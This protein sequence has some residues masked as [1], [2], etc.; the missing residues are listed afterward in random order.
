MGLSKNITLTIKDYE[1]NLDK[2]IKFYER[3][4]INLCFSILEYGIVVKD[5][6]PINK[7]MPIQ[8]LRAFMLIE[9]PEGADFAEATNIE[10]NKVVFNLG[11]RYSQFIGIGRMQIVIKDYDGCRVTLPEFFFEIKESINSNWDEGTTE[12]P[13]TEDERIITDELGRPIETVKLSE[14]EE[15]SDITFDTYTMVIDKDGNKKMKVQAVADTVTETIIEPVVESVTESVKEPIRLAV[16]DDIVVEYTD[17]E[18]EVQFPNVHNIV[19]ETRSLVDDHITNHPKGVEVVNDLISGGIDKALS[20]EQGKNLNVLVDDHITNHP[21]GVEVVDDLVSGGKDKALSAEQGKNLNSLV[22]DHITNHP[23]GVEIIDSLTVGGIDKALSAEQGKNLN[24][25]LMG[26]TEEYEPEEVS[27]EYPLVQEIE[28]IRDYVDDHIV[29]H[30]S[31]V[32]VV[33]SLTVGGKDKALSAECGKELKQS[34]IDMMEEYDPEEIS[35]E[36]PL[37]QEIENIGTEVDGLRSEMEEHLSNHPSADVNVMRTLMININGTLEER[38]DVASCIIPMDLE[39]IKIKVMAI[40]VPEEG[41]LSFNIMKNGVAMFDTIPNLV[42]SSVTELTPN[43]FDL[44]E[45]DVLSVDI[46]SNGGESLNIT[47]VCM[48]VKDNG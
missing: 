26:V 38:I 39:I 16:I 3:D 7:L 46:I 27:L 5:G 37:V 4:T 24:L 34:L 9:T 30:P 36:Y 35:L 20:A 25:L 40:S 12:F 41:G 31:G 43:T 47:M 42:D 45:N 28:N 8:A 32:E 14:L 22:D 29:N 23:K 19:E 13:S 10:D 33:D 21:K 44:A 17:E 1:V 6:V 15:T 2:E 18:L 11:N 48:E